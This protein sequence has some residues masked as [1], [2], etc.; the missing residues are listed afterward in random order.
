MSDAPGLRSVA[1]VAFALFGLA[2]C[3]TCKGRERAIAVP[4]AAR[5]VVF[6]GMCDASGA[7]PLSA[8]RFVVADDEGNVLR[9]YDADRGGAPIDSIDLSAQLGLPLKVN[10]KGRAKPAPEVD[11]EAATRSGELAFWLTS[12]ARS[13]SGKEKPERQRFFATKLPADGA[14]LVLEGEVYEGLVDELLAD[15]RFARFHLR[16]AL[17]L[18]PKDPA[19]STSKA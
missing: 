12:H 15:A 13:S 7:V 1:R 3:A 8:S 5:E 6:T 9:V 17:E 19:A 10:K 18:G 11:I 4:G 16:E 2:A 14:P